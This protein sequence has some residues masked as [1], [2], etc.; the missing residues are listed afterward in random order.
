MFGEGLHAELVALKDRYDRDN[1]FRLNQNIR[2]S[3]GA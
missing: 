1:V 3:S 2:P